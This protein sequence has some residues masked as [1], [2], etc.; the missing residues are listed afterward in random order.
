MSTDTSPAVVTATA[1]HL[2]AIRASRVDD[3]AREMAARGVRLTWRQL[4]ALDDAQRGWLLT[5]LDL[6]QVD[7]DHEYVLFLP[8]AEAAK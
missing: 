6:T 5:R 3:Y 2:S 8:A 4:R 1:R 7:S